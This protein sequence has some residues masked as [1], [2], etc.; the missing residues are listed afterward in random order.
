MAN[1]RF[2]LKDKDSKVPT[3]IMARL[4]Y[5]SK[6]FSF[7]TGETVEPIYWNHEKQKIKENVKAIDFQWS[8]RILEKVRSAILGAYRLLQEENKLITNDL[9]KFHTDTLLGK[10]K[11][12]QTS[13]SSL[14]VHIEQVIKNRLMK[15]DEPKDDVARKYTNTFKRLKDYS[16]KY[17]H[18][19]LEYDDININFYNQF[20]KFLTAIPL[21]PNTIGKEIKTLKR[22]MNLATLEGSNTNLLF[23]STEFKAP[24]KVIKHVYLDEAEVNKLYT[25]ELSTK[26][27]EEIRDLFIIG[28]RTSL[29][30]SDY[31][32]V[33][34]DNVSKTG[35]ICIDE[36]EKTEDPAYIPMHWQ[37]KEILAK[38]NGL[39]PMHTTQVIDKM[40]KPICRQA[41]F[42]N[43]VRDTRQGRNKISDEVFV[44]KYELIS[45]HTGRRSCITN[46]YLADFDIYFLKSLTGHRSVETLMSYIGVEHKLNA[47]KLQDNAFFKKAEIKPI[48]E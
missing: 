20:I 1:L 21:A 45:S 38:Y 15:T 2:Y 8:N 25:L 39:P 16:D 6:Q 7:S 33:I 24:K 36:T 5:S 26:L 22:F 43:K 14:F 31:D 42:K 13:S 46:L 32:K 4:N 48:K 17:L 9:L 3:L 40:I 18:R 30:V 34:A 28:C 27:K 47:M 10:V 11:Q 19:P 23:K 41:G 37:V 35:L 44:P 29:R 12:S